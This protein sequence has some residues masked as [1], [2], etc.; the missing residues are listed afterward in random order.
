LQLWVSSSQTPPELE[1]PPL[2]LDEEPMLVLVVLVPPL[3]E[4]AL[5]VE[6]LPPLELELDGGTGMPLVQI[7][8][9]Q[10]PEMQSSFTLQAQPRG[11]L[12][13]LPPGR[14]QQT[15]PTQLFEMQ[16][17]LPVQPQL[18]WELA[19]PL[20]GAPQITYGAGAT[21]PASIQKAGGVP[22]TRPAS[23]KPSTQLPVQQGAS[24]EQA[25]PAAM[26]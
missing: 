4:L 23:L 8:N 24:T 6:L 5:L 20:P 19:C 13:R 10:L 18:G 1:L 16:S 7:P 21:I 15:E 9:E 22:H 12:A 11:E 17:E 2:L 3:E 25:W 26:Q 14:P